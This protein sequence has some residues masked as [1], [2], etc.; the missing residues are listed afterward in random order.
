M[1]VKGCLQWRAVF[2]RPRGGQDVLAD[3]VE[4]IAAQDAGIDPH[5]G[6]AVDAKQPPSDGSVSSSSRIC[7]FG[8]VWTL[9]LPFRPHDTR[10]VERDHYA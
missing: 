10:R 5:Q 6:A 7:T 8:F 3:I 4:Q 9:R 2:A 1:K